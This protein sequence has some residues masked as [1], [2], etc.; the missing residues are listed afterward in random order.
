MRQVRKNKVII[1]NF[2]HS[3]SFW[4]SLTFEISL[5]SVCT[6]MHGE[7]RHLVHLPSKIIY[8]WWSK[9]VSDLL[10]CK[11]ISLQIIIVGVY[12]YSKIFLA[13][14]IYAMLVRNQF[15]ESARLQT[16]SSKIR[17]LKHNSVAFLIII[18]SLNSAFVRR[19]PLIVVVQS[20]YILNHFLILVTPHFLNSISRERRTLRFSLEIPGFENLAFNWAWVLQKSAPSK[21]QRICSIWLTCQSDLSDEQSHSTIII[22]LAR[23]TLSLSLE[24]SFLIRPLIMW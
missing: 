2:I 8:T 21:A 3:H 17:A 6:T 19:V 5:H 4:V 12:K 24:K 1:L 15:S 20:L 7:K 11:K 14:T 18:I 22:M 16:I 13:I 23:L 10:A 9:V